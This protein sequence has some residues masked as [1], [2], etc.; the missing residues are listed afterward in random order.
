[1]LTAEEPKLSAEENKN[2]KPIEKTAENEVKPA[3][4]ENKAIS[5]DKVKEEIAETKQ[6]IKKLESDI[7][8]ENDE[9]DDNDDDIVIPPPPEFSVP[10]FT[11]YIHGRQRSISISSEL[12]NDSYLYEET[13][14]TVDSSGENDS[15]I[16]ID[17]ESAVN[18]EVSTD[19]QSPI[20]QKIENKQNEDDEKDDDTI[21]D[22]P[23]DIEIKVPV[24][25]EDIIAQATEPVNGNKKP[26]LSISTDETHLNVNSH[27]PP[28]R[29]SASLSASVTRQEGIEDES[30]TQ[31]KNNFLGIFF[32]LTGNDNSQFT[33]KINNSTSTSTIQLTKDC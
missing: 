30:K 8:K 24:L 4:N 27:I 26:E 7:H 32:I 29:S 12:S 25:A 14:I 18:T 21:K 22:V 3:E 28:P 23:R 20:H 5:I 6:E 1:M 17:N 9:N 10:L 2:D 15:I 33:N 13:N 31:N 11:K 19:I 16:N